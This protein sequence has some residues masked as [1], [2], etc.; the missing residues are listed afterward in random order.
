MISDEI[1]RKLQNIIRGDVLEGQ[2]DHC[3]A[4]RNLL[5]QSFGSDP[6]VKREFESRSVLKEEQA[7]FLKSYAENNRLWIPALA[8]GS[9]YL[10]RGGESEIYLA[11]DHRHVIKVNDA[12]YYA[13][14]T[15]YFNSLVIHNL[16]FPSTAYEL[17]GFTACKDS[18]LCVVLRQPFIEGGQANLAN[19]KEHLT[20]NGFRNTKRQDYFNEEFGLILEDMHDENV[21][22]RGDVLFF[23]DT[24]FYIMEKE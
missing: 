18:V 10:T 19:I 6:T 13:T 3:T 7:R 4:I 23:I 12:V 22:S 11:P 2:E 24:V 17:S 21:I 9:Q 15:E 1:R 14:W 5:C 20:F 8:E 16:L